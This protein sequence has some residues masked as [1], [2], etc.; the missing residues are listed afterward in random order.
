AVFW[1]NIKDED[2]VKQ[3]F[4]KAAKRIAAE[5]PS[6]GLGAIGDD[7]LDEVV[8]AVKRWL[9][10]PKNTQWLMVFDNYDNPKLPGVTDPAA[11]DIRQ[12]FPDAYHGSVLVT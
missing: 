11:V 9:D 4:T 10:R 3:S 6:S 1:L 8:R 12:F 5:Y 7:N 2:S